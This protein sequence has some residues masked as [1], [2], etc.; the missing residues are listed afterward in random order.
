MFPKRRWTV[1][2]RSTKGT[3]R[4]IVAGGPDGLFATPPTMPSG[5]G[6]LVST[7]QDYMRFSQM[8][9]NGGE[10]ASDLADRVDVAALHE[11]CPEARV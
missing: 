11:A 4:A 2:Q 7:A 3:R 8:F 5:G 9:L 10:L 6:G 1:L